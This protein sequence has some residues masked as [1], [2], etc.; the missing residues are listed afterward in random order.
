MLIGLLV[1]SV[2][3]GGVIFIR[4]RDWFRAEVKPVRMQSCGGGDDEEAEFSSKGG[5][6]GASKVGGVAERIASAAKRA[7]STTAK[8]T[9]K[10][11]A[12]TAKAT[13]KAASTTSKAAAGAKVSK[14]ERKTFAR[15]HDIESK[16]VVDPDGHA[17]ASGSTS[18]GSKK[19]GAA[20]KG[21]GSRGTKS[22]KKAATPGV[23]SKT[24]RKVRT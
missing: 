4:R 24:K 16:G 3:L 17:D 21:E 2:V 19:A 13:A 9:A 1:G 8:A 7:A 20:A 22:G 10:A 23:D 14:G 12:S 18:S 15:Q 5:E 11:A 6:G